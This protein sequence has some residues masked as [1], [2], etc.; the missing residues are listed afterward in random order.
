VVKQRDPGPQATLWPVVS[1]P[2]QQAPG[3]QP[4]LV[5][6]VG[7]QRV[8]GRCGQT[9]SAQPNPAGWIHDHMVGRDPA[10]A[11]PDTVQV[12]HRRRQLAHRPHRPWR[13]QARGRRSSVDPGHG[14]RQHK[15]VGTAVQSNQFHHAGMAYLAQ[16]G[17][18]V[19]QRPGPSRTGNLCHHR[20]APAQGG[21]GESPAVHTSTLETTLVAT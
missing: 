14:G 11:Q 6:V 20:R 1:G 21:H 7:T 18:L 3:N 4:Y 13:R 17:G 15:V 8:G 19:G 12:G 5:N 16:D 9:E 10:V 2:H